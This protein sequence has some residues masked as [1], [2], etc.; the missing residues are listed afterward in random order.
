MFEG[1]T[2]INGQAGQPKVSII[3]VVY[4]AAP[5][6]KQYMANV[7]P[8]LNNDD[9]ELVMI[10][11]NSTDGTLGLLQE[12]NDRIDYWRSE[13]D[14]GI[15][16]AMNKAITYS[17]GK[18]MFFLGMDDNLMDGF[19]NMVADLKDA[20]TIYYGN[21]V[22]YGTPYR[23]V[24]DDYYLTKLNLVHQSIFY[25]R[26]VFNKYRYDTK[27]KVY[28]DYHLNLRLWH[29]QDFKFVYRDH[30]V[31]GFPEGGFSSTAADPVFERDRDRLFKKYLGKKAYYRY[32]NRTLGW[33]KTL[34]RMVTNG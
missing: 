15:Y 7:L 14:D 33:F 11:G 28:A 30:W 16:D 13:P 4:N 9:V 1:G 8:Y 29:D 18:W 23:K 19:H 12:Y 32:L 25:P 10:D 22:Y 21:T 24:Y 27:Y 5:L 31:A 3:T 20:R 6:F 2:R 17:Q 34:I 26:A